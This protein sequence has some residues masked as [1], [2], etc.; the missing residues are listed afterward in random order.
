MVKQ[1]DS[2]DKLPELDIN[3]RCSK[4]AKIWSFSTQRIYNSIFRLKIFIVHK[5]MDLIQAITTLEN[6][7]PIFCIY[8]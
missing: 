5:Q 6:P 4:H 2:T 1:S 3:F 8:Y 7:F